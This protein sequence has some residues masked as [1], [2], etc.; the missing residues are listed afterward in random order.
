MMLTNVNDSNR[1]FPVC[2]LSVDFATPDDALLVLIWV[3]RTKL[4]ADQS[5]VS[6]TDFFPGELVIYCNDA[7]EISVLPGQWTG[8][9]FY[10]NDVFA[11]A[12]H[13]WLSLLSVRISRIGVF[14]SISFSCGI[15]SKIGRRIQ[16]F[17]IMN[18]KRWTFTS[19]SMIRM[20]EG[21]QPPRL[22]F[23]STAFASIRLMGTT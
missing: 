8:S 6:D 22:H 3:E 13:C 19:I 21:V 16:A 4:L 14:S 10:M 5:L 9:E 11:V 7:S 17:P 23:V 12:F 18:G 20:T 1:W 15:N 2:R